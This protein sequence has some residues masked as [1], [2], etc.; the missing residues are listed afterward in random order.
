MAKV[1]I[2]DDSP[3]IVNTLSS[4]L[5]SIGHHVIGIADNGRDGVKKYFELHPDIVTMDINMPQL[6]GISA[7]KEICGKDRSAKVIMISSIEDKR[8]VYEALIDGA[9]DYISKPIQSDELA[10]KISKYVN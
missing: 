2:I 10:Q 5:E 4:M 6:D 8:I 3:Y 1:L 9:E 7:L